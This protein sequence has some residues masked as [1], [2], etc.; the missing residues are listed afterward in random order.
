MNPL[1]RFSFFVVVMTSV[2]TTS[3]QQAESTHFVSIVGRFGIALPQNEAVQKPFIKFEISGQKFSG[4]GFQWELDSEKVAVDF[5]DGALDLESPSQAEVF[6][7]SVR[8]DYSKKTGQASLVGEKRTSLQGHS[9]LIFIVQSDSNRTMGWLYLVKNRFY[10]MTLSL[11]DPAKTQEHVTLVSS[12]FRILARSDVEPRYYQLADKLTP[13]PLPQEASSL[14]MTSDLQD[15]GLKGKIKQIITEKEDY[16]GTELFDVRNIESVDYYNEQGN[17]VKS[18]SSPGGIPTGVRVYGYLSGERVYRERK[19]PPVIIIAGSS[20]QKQ[21]TTT[22]GT[23]PQDKT[24]KV[25]YKF[26]K[27]GQV[28][29]MRVVRD[30]GQEMETYVFA[31]DKR[32]IEHTFLV[33]PEAFNALFTARVVSALDTNGNII[34]DDQYRREAPERVVTSVGGQLIQGEKERFKIDRITYKYEFDSQ[35]NWIKRTAYSITTKKGEMIENTTE[36]GKMIETPL[37]VTHRSI[38]YY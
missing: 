22:R 17:L 36:K 34:A 25:R 10:L 21:G 15:W 32:K 14:K 28:L 9:G 35:G 5:A 30:D 26:D 19:T 12:S 24:Y 13:S 3:G 29:E 2:L 38:I 33:L 4:S 20:S 11:S 23:E 37:Y 16:F 27:I 8:D 31:R 18:I 6:L 7:K 1:I